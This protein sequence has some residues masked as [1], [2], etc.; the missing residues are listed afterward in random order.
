MGK[1]SLIMW[2]S[3]CT[4]GNYKKKADFVNYF[5][6][7]LNSPT[8]PYKLRQTKRAC[9]STKNIMMMMMMMM[10]TSRMLSWLALSWP[11]CFIAC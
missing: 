1:K 6:N 11:Q 5:Q 9:Y 7:Y 10:M 3:L 2:H 8:K 4:D